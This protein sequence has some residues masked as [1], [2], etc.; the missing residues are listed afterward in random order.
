MRDVCLDVRRAA[1]DDALFG[2]RPRHHRPEALPL[3]R[4]PL[5]RVR[6]RKVGDRARGEAR[7]A[8]EH[9]R[10]LYVGRADLH[11]PP[12]RGLGTHRQTGA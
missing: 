12:N 2:R 10:L 3:W 4:A 1:N 8:L 11:P 7:V 6:A 9:L 5:L